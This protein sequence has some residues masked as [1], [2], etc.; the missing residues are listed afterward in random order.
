MKRF[1]PKFIALFAIIIGTIAIYY[2]CIDPRVTQDLSG[3]RKL[4]VGHAYADSIHKLFPI[5]TTLVI[6]WK[7][8]M[9]IPKKTV[10]RILPQG[11]LTSL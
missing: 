11:E 1:L 4:P 10:G 7:E 5:D 2:F 9:I 8:G 3:M 6:L